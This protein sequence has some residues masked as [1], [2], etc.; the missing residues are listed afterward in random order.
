M[1][2]LDLIIDFVGCPRLY[3]PSPKSLKNYLFNIGKLELKRLRYL[4]ALWMMDCSI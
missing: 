3:T 1:N 4:Q 2:P